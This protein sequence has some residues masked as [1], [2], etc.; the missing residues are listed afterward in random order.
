MVPARISQKQIGMETFV[1]AIS[2]ARRTR[3]TSR[4]CMTAPPPPPA[5]CRR[6]RPPRRKSSPTASIASPAA[7]CRSP[8]NSRITSSC[9]KGGQSEARGLAVIAETRR[10]FPA[11]KIKYV[12]A[13]ASALRS[14]RAASPPFVA[15]GITILVDDNAQVLHRGVARHAADAGR[16]RDGEVAQE[17]EGRG[18][19]RADGAEGRRRTR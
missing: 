13:H 9:S 1:V 19:D 2:S 18:R 15:E 6:C 3:P 8:S 10:L 5:A 11:K 14:C 17:A 16:R 12:V 7:T 4:S